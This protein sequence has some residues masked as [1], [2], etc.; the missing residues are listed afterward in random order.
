MGYSLRE[1]CGLAAAYSLS[2]E[3]MSPHLIKMGRALQHRGQE[4]WGLAIEGHKLFKSPGLIYT[5]VRRH[6]RRLSRLEGF[7]GIQHNRYSTSGSSIGNI[8]PIDVN[9]AFIIAHN[10]TIENTDYFKNQL[11]E[12]GFTPNTENPSDTYLVGFWLAQ[13]QKITG[14]WKETFSELSE[15]A[16]GAF[17]LVMLTRDGTVYAARDKRGFKPLV[18]G[19]TRESYFVASESCAF[20]AIEAELVR[21]VEPGELIKINGN[22]VS[23]ETFAHDT[24]LNIDP[25]EFVYFAHPSS[26]IHGKV[27]YQVRK[28]IGRELARKYRLKGDVVIGVPESARPAALGY[29]EEMGI[30]YEDI[31]MKDRYT[32]P[33]VLRGFIQPDQQLRTEIANSMSTVK[34]MVTGRNVIVVDDSIVRSTSSTSF[35]SQLRRANPRSISLLITFFPIRHPCYMGI[36]FPDRRE[37]FVPGFDDGRMS[38]EEINRVGAQKLGA[39]FLGYN[40]PATLARAIGLP[41]ESICQSCF[42]GEYRNLNLRPSFKRREEVR[43]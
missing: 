5:A 4:G 11:S 36:D 13:R 43:V 35:V 38:I 1:N 26:V 12:Y 37:L 23:S 9:G 16:N 33:S 7:S 18:L 27:V 34:E 42:T 19:K 20:D 15:V 25:F 3:N 28:N 17:C 10:G 8:Q 30:P 22:G 2:G 29:A 39:D 14:D 24:R 6:Q 31:L 32:R 40:D 21:D 41:V